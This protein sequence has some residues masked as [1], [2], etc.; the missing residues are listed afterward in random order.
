MAARDDALTLGTV[1]VATPVSNNPVA[2]IWSVAA[3]A[4]TDDGMI[5]NLFGHRDLIDRDNETVVRGQG[6]HAVG[7]TLQLQRRRVS[8]E[9]FAQGP[10]DREELRWR[11]HQHR[12]DAPDPIAGEI[13]TAMRCG[14]KDHAPNIAPVL[15]D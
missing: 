9:I 7:K 4:V 13:R 2:T 12:P 11:S 15:E 1:E 5:G 10:T 3:T 6:V 8:G 14:H